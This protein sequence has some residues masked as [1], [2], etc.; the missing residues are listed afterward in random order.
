MIRTAP[1]RRR[2][3][4]RD[5]SAEEL[6]RR[7]ERI[8]IAA[9]K[10]S[11]A[12]PA[13]DYRAV[14]HGRGMEFS[15]VREYRAGDDIRSIDWNVTARAGE[16]FVKVFR[17]ERDRTLLL[18][19]DLSASSDFGT[20]LATKRDLAAEAAAAIALSAASSRDRVGAIL[21]TDRIEAIRRPARG[22]SHA[23]A[24]V[25]EI[26]SR[27]LEGF[28]TD[29]KLGLS[30]ARN[31]LKSRAMVILL[32]DFRTSG[33]ERELAALARKHEV[34]ALYIHDPAE[35]NFPSRGLFQ[36]RDA[37]TGRVRLTDAA[38]PMF[39]RHWREASGERARAIC[40]RAGIDCLDLSSAR[41]PSRE[42]A[43]FFHARSRK[44]G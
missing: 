26:L 5:L 33:Y 44:R 42:I 2:R 20:R 29:L 36:F 18:L 12:L 9:R 6:A 8:S 7:V 31:L 37:E 39:R 15:E 22:K 40:A 17:E 3:K 10:K 27:P 34:I 32:S 19:A 30:S 25:R 28:G 16:P 35:T 23:L 38:S 4:G 21:F 1:P 24:L 14:F 43:A 11:D 13:G 41:A